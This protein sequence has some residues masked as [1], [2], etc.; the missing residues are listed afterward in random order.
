MPSD[1]GVWEHL[2]WAF[3]Q[4]VLRRSGRRLEPPRRRRHVVHPTDL[5]RLDTE[6]TEF[7]LDILAEVRIRVR[8]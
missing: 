2:Q 1:G 8:V 6:I 5:V 3:V 4:H 7:A